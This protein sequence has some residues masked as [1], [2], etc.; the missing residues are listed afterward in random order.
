MRPARTGELRLQVVQ[1]RRHTPARRSLFH[2]FLVAFARKAELSGEEAEARSAAETG[3]E[4]GEEEVEEVEV[5][6]ES[7]IRRR[8]S[9]SSS[10][11]PSSP[12]SSVPFVT[13]ADSEEESDAAI[14]VRR[15]SG[16]SSAG[17][18]EGGAA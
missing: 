5:A 12:V 2:C 4:E 17:G 6:A 9:L 16:Q 11:C 1:K 18:N 3:V 10:S 8:L 15:R 14:V 7:M 13:S